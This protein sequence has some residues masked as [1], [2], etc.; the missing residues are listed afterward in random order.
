MKKAHSLQAGFH[1][2]SGSNH[3]TNFCNGKAFAL[4]LPKGSQSLYSVTQARKP[5]FFSALNMIYI[6]VLSG[7]QN[8]FVGN[9]GSRSIAVES[10]RCLYGITLKTIGGIIMPKI[11]TTPQPSQSQPFNPFHPFGEGVRIACIDSELFANLEDLCS[12]HGVPYIDSKPLEY[13]NG[14]VAML[15]NEE[16]GFPNHLYLG[17]GAFAVFMAWVGDCH[18]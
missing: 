18:E 5:W 14:T 13:P 12:C 7:I 6:R 2:D 1:G 11:T 16:G 9:T 8:P 15:S 17:E 10:T 4:S 3:A